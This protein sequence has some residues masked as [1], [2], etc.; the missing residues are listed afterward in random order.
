MRDGFCV[1]PPICR[2][3]SQ[4][5]YGRRIIGLVCKGETVGKTR[6]MDEMGERELVLVVSVRC[7]KERVM[8]RGC[9]IVFKDT[10]ICNPEPSSS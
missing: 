4:G 8:T 7:D 1:D 5:L 9:Q 6:E 10:K 3:T 2:G